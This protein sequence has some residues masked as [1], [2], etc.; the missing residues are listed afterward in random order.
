MQTSLLWTIVIVSLV[1]LFLGYY[2]GLVE[3]R[4]RAERKYKKELEERD[5]PAAIQPPPAPVIVDNP[6]L[7]RLKDENGQFLLEMDGARVNGNTI[8]RMRPWVEGRPMPGGAPA[9]SFSFASPDRPAPVPAP[10][11]PPVVPV[12]APSLTTPRKDPPILAQSMVEQIDAI[13]QE[14]IENTPLGQRGLKLEEAPG[15][16]VNVVV[17]L[18][19]YQGVGEVPDP[20]VQAAI[21]AAIAEWE[22]KF[23]PG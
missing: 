19:R 20:E 9:S 13:L 2:F 7:L 16:A 22:R 15:G 1:T 21:R 17:G 10:A 14:K 23:T 18:N 5:A 11:A 12:A 3:G 6:G 8:T 4:V